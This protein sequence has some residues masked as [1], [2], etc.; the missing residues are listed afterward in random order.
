MA[1]AN[2]LFNGLWDKGDQLTRLVP[3][4]DAKI[5]GR[6]NASISTYTTESVEDTFRMGRVFES[7]QHQAKTPISNRALLAEFLIL[8]L[9][10]CIVL[11]LPHEVIVADVAYLAILLAFGRGITLLPMMVACIQSELRVLAKIFCRVKVLVD[12]EGN[13]LTD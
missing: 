4:T 7:F 12:A 1:R 13:V 11:T 2:Y 6:I 10:Q 8:W 3:S 5:E 9:K